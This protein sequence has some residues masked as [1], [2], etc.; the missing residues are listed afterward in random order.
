MRIIRA[1]RPQFRPGAKTQYADSNYVLLGII[2][3][4]VTGR[5]AES[6]ISAT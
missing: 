1:N 5:S 3:E 2:L 6:V 4:K